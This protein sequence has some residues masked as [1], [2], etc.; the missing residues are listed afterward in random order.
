MKRGKP[1]APAFSYVA[2]QRLADYL[3]LPKAPREATVDV[4]G[5]QVELLTRSRCYRESQMTCLTCHD[6]H[7]EQRDVT[8]LSGRCLTCHTEKACGLFPSRG[9]AILGRCVDCHM[10]LQPSSQIVSKLQ[11]QDEQAMIRT[12][13]IRVYQKSMPR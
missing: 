10:P 5:N 8:E 4:H 13:Y 1:N 3:T 11:G 2:G 6:V 7:R 9:R 12:H